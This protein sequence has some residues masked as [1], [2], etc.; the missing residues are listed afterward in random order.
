M[1][2]EGLEDF[3]VAASRSNRYAMDQRLLVRFYLHP[4]L[5]REETAQEG[6]PIYKDREYVEIL[7][8]GNKDSIVQRPATVQDKQRFQ[9]QYQA[10]KNNEQEV[11]KGTPLE[12]WGG[13]TRSQV[14]ELRFFNV[15]TVEQLADMTDG[16]AQGFMG[17]NQ[18]R[19]RAQEFLGRQSTEKRDEEMEAL[20]QQN[21]QMQAAI[22]ELQAAAGKKEPVAS[23]ETPDL[24]AGAKA[25]DGDGET[26]P[27]RQR[28][29]AAS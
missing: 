15:R 22:T 26:K 4:H 28:R 8:P 2:T 9:V 16:N 25:E 7:Q 21:A 18:L 19:Q 11:L 13:L 5:Q 27:R 29:R 17:I 10:F 23:Q 12:Q 14:E 24:D 6:R 20:R 3:A 1:E